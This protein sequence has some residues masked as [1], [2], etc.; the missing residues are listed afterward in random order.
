MF[1]ISCQICKE[2]ADNTIAADGTIYCDECFYKSRPPILILTTL[3][4]SNDTS[5][6]NPRTLQFEC[7]TRHGFERCGFHLFNEKIFH[8]P[9]F[10]VMYHKVL[11][12]RYRGNLRC[13][14]IEGYDYWPKNS[15]TCY[16]TGCMKKE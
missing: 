11:T 13:R 10:S 2:P 3:W 1:E 16:F 9:K 12:F 4:D 14:K 5:L 7:L 8:L 6:Y 15:K